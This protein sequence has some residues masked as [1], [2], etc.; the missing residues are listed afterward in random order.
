MDSISISNYKLTWDKYVNYLT[1]DI[2]IYWLVVWNMFCFCIYW[3]QSSHM[4]H[5]FKG[6]ETNSQMSIFGINGLGVGVCLNLLVDH[7]AFYSKWLVGW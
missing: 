6:F 2:H 1:W 4:T 3:E 5:I 7:H